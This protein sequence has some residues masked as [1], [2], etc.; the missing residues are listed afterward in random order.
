MEDPL[1]V[2]LKPV[3]AVLEELNVLYYIGGSV[4]SMTHG[5][6][7][8]TADVDI[9][10]DLQTQHI[11]FFVER[12]SGA[13]M[14]DESMIRSSLQSGIG[15]NI[16]HLTE[17]FK[18]DIFPLK[19]RLYDQQAA[20]RRVL[21]TLEIEPPVQA[22]VSTP[23]D[24]VL[25]KLEWFRSGGETSERQWR[26]VLGVLKINC[27]DINIEYLERWAKELR[28]DDLLARAFDESG[29]TNEQGQ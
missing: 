12:L 17:F 2:A 25:A 23:E 26:D 13:F 9:V 6:Y 24:I 16:I 27:F 1:G 4:A 14:A 3:I 15:F 5:E 19:K 18:V 11:P 21:E 29:I 8:Q 10:A 20:H 22:Y 7:R 28:I